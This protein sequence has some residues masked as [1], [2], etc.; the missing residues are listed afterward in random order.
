MAIVNNSALM[1]KMVILKYPYR[2][3]WVLSYIGIKNKKTKKKASNLR[4]T[5]FGC[6]SKYRHLK[7]YIK[8]LQVEIVEQHY[9]PNMNNM[10]GQIL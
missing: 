9:T 3:I 7:K 8:Q 10:Q 2:D 4:H 1:G 6:K 5:H